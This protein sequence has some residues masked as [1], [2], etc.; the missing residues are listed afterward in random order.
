MTEIVR[1]LSIPAPPYDWPRRVP[2]PNNDVLIFLQSDQPPTA[3]T[4]HQTREQASEYGS[5]PCCLPASTG[6]RHADPATGPYHEKD[7]K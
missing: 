6:H 5:D 3:S 2:G 1:V 4:H 7:G